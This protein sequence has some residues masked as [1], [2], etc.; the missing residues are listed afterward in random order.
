MISELKTETA[1][2]EK[3]NRKDAVIHGVLTVILMLGARYFIRMI[4]FN[5]FTNIRKGGAIK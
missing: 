4:L 2:L 5:L 3:Q 1:V